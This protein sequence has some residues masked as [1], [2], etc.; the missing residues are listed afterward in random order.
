MNVPEP[1]FRSVSYPP[2]VSPSPVVKKRFP[3]FFSRG[4]RNG[5]GG[6]PR[7]HTNLEVA[8]E[9]CAMLLRINSLTALIRNPELERTAEHLRQPAVGQQSVFREHSKPRC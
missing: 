8:A 9:N 6:L 5:N 7:V 1:A 3:A 4:F 2:R